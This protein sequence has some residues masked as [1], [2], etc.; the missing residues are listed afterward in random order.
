MLT[1]L[2]PPAYPKFRLTHAEIT[3]LF[4]TELLPFA[5]VVELPASKS[6]KRYRFILPNRAHQAKSPTRGLSRFP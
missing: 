2:Q 4:D 1:S 5:D 3:F 6:R